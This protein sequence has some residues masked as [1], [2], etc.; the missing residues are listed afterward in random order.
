MSQNLRRIDTKLDTFCSV[1]YFP[2]NLLIIIMVTRRECSFTNVDNS[3]LLGLKD[4]QLIIT[5]FR[6][7]YGCQR[8]SRCTQ[9]GAHFF[10]LNLKNNQ[11]LAGVLLNLKL[12]RALS[13]L[14]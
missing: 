13:S 1:F 10:K 2:Y 12:K 3:T 4:L 6:I 14:V 5:T 8:F 7:L 9:L 11:L